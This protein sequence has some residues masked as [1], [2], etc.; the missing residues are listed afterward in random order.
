MIKV[1]IIGPIPPPYHGVSVATSLILNSN[2][3]NKFHLIHHDSSDRRGIE[4][5]G[6]IDLMNIFY[7]IKD[8]F[9]LF[10]LL[11]KKRPKIVYIPICQTR[12][13][14]LRD[15]FY[16]LVTKLFRAK[17]IV[18]LH[19]SYFRKLYEESNILFKLLVKYSLKLISRAIVLADCLRYIF[20]GLIPS[21]K[22]SV[23]HNGIDDPYKDRLEKKSYE[24]ANPIKILYLSN[25]MKEKGYVDVLRAIPDVIKENPQVK[26]FF[27][28]EY[29]R[30][31]DKTFAQKFIKKNRLEPYIKHL[32]AISGQEKYDLLFDSDIFVFPSYN[33]GMPFVIIEAMS[34]GLPII[35]TN[36]G[37][38]KEMV[39]DGEN[40]FIV[41]K[42]NPQQIA[43]KIIY[44][45]KN[46][47]IRKQMGLKSRERFLKYYTKEHFIDALQNIFQSV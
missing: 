35:S 6:K 14:F 25:L 8:F 34:A 26:F 45:I 32:G 41:E 47:E 29:W 31:D 1:I 18:H 20:E 27:A 37:A 11:L 13:G 15:A 4:N 12:I 39:I 46:P 38:I 9:R 22:I 43:E 44:F 40:G 21:D 19:G 17:I 7:A 23:V 28:G 2:L 3:K 30:Q 16:I 24:S 33:E 36:V 5:I 10:L 42:Q